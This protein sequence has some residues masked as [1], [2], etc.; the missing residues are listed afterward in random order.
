MKNSFYSLRELKQIGFKK[1]GKD[2]QVSRKASFYGVSNISIGNNSR[3][4]DFC[5]LS[6][7]IIIG[8]H[9]HIAVG[10]CLFGGEAGIY[11]SDFSGVSSRGAIYAS[12][13]DYSGLFLTN[14][15]VPSEFRNVIEK[16][17]VVGRH[18]V[19]GTGST[20]L[21]GVTIGDYSAIGS[22]TLVNKSLDERGI[23]I[24]IPAKRIKDRDL[25][26]VE[27]EKR[28]YKKSSL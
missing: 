26:I 15:T 12:S 7:K 6:G 9:V 3:I 25:N 8:N 28:L 4:D 23:Y 24:G 18:V 5:V 20:V 21:P 27:L 22:M 2:V 14:P 10:S 19:I 13:D 16:S 1:I 17:V 11:M